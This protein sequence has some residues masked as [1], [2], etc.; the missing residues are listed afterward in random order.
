MDRN[1][2]SLADDNFIE[3]IR[4]HARWQDRCEC[5]EEHG[6]LLLAGATSLPFP[7]QNC[8]VRT[9]GALSAQQ[10][11]DRAREFFGSRGRGFILFVRTG[12]DEDL[13]LLC[14]TSGLRLLSDTPCMLITKPFQSVDSP[15]SIR[16]E[17]I[18]A[19][20]HVRDAISIN[21]EA[22][23]VFGAPPKA[24]TATYG[25]PSKLLS[26]PNVTGYVLYRENR[27]VSTAL[28]IF[29]GKGAGIYWVGTVP[30]AERTGLATISTR[31]ATNAGFDRGASAVTLQASS[32]GEPIYVRLGYQTYDHLKWYMHGKPS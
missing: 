5:I 25:N 3:S 17:S 18:T 23:R 27:P 24:I 30:D 2:Q 15:D 6:L 22:Y 20:Q 32:Y 9:D 13:D 16:I 12:Q 26:S 11:L 19:E 21:S 29:S 31:L 28:T 4:E 8:L 14:Q 10:V 1:L 7:Y